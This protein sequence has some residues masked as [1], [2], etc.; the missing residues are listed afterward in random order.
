MFLTNRGQKNSATHN[1]RLTNSEGGYFAVA[2]RK[3]SP[4]LEKRT[5]NRANAWSLAVLG[6]DCRCSSA[7]NPRWL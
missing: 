7:C 6:G 4:S 1:S 5:A 2:G 3:R